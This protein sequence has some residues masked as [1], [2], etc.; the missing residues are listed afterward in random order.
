MAAASWFDLWVSGD[1]GG[2]WR[3]VDARL[4][5]AASIVDRF[6]AHA[7]AAVLAA[8]AEEHERT[9]AERASVGELLPQLPQGDPRV[10]RAHLTLRATTFHEGDEPDLDD[11]IERCIAGAAGD[12][13]LAH[14]GARAANNRLLGVLEP[15]R[16]PAAGARQSPVDGWLAIADARAVADRLGHRM[17]ID[18]QAVDFAVHHGDWQRAMTWA[19]EALDASIR[20]TERLA[21]QAKAAS[22][23]WEA[24]DAADARTFGLEALA[25]SAGVSVVWA[26]LYGMVGGVV[27]AAAGAGSVAAALERYR[28]SVHPSEHAT[29]RHRAMRVAVT[30]FDATGDRELVE[31]FLRATIGDAHDQHERPL[32]TAI[33]EGASWR[34]DGSLDALID[35]TAAP[36][37]VLARAHVMRARGRRNVG[38]ATAAAVDVLAA[39]RLLA[40]WRG[41]ALHEVDAL[42]ATEGIAPAVTPRQAEVRDLVVEGLADAEIAEALGIAVRTVAVHVHALLAAHGVPSR[43]ALAVAVLR[44]RLLAR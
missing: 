17:A 36:A 3:L 5:A 8:L 33:T 13:E 28:R 2:A 37:A 31:R 27:A 44:R 24:G 40:G 10:E 14:I 22:L 43:T 42:L 38:R 20:P 26:R 15:A 35:T 29:R 12:P 21:L 7:D 39:R 18:R 25:S 6:V 34:D 32:L 16:Q 4:H 11:V 30:A 19:R 1:R 9:L 41:P 23:A